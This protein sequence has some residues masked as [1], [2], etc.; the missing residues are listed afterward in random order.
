MKFDII[1]IIE[2]STTVKAEA[3]K[4]TSHRKSD[5]IRNGIRR[6]EDQKVFQTSRLG[7][8]NQD[9][10]I[11]DTKEFGGLGT[12]H[13]YGFAPEASEKRNCQSVDSSAL[14]SYTEA[15]SYLCAKYPDFIFSGQCSVVNKT[16]SLIS[17]YGLDLSTQSG[18][19]D[20]YFIYQKKG[21]G[22]MMD[23]YLYGSSPKD[24]ILQ[25]VKAQEIYLKTSDKVEKIQ[26]GRYPVLLVEEKNPL[27]KLLESFHLN[28]YS[29]ASALYSGKLKTKLFSDKVT[30]YDSG[31]DSAAGQY[32]FFDGEGVVRT[33]DQK[34]IEGGVFNST[35]SDLRFS[36]KYSGQSTGNGLR[37]YNR[38]VN[39]DFKNLRFKKGI[40]PWKEIVSNLPVCIVALVCAGGDSNDLGEFSSPVQIGYVYRYGE[41]V[42]LAPQ[43]TLKTSI[44]Q[45]LDKNLI[46]ISSDGFTNDSPSGCVISEM[47]ILLNS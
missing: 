5:I 18:L 6:F 36:K 42:G 3:S 31:Y 24:S 20:W 19:I 39:V 11:A 28:K 32:N 25:S 44:E 29:D 22:N 40:R 8:A 46:D 4:I 27:K 7:E 37:L 45:Y 1:K 33:M 43:V 12:L 47:D 9:R 23:G 15:L 30:I 34:L 35:I 21:S 17:N 38:G 10:L 14:T 13:E 41:I 16:L 2:D 26:S